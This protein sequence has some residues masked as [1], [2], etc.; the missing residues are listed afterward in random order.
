METSAWEVLDTISGVLVNVTILLGAAV[1]VI[2]F[3][4]YNILGHRYRSEIACAHEELADGRILFRGNYIVHNIGERQIRINKV[5]LKLHKA[6][7]RNGIVEPDDSVV[8]AR[9]VV[10]AGGPRKGLQQ[11]E[12]GERSIFTLRTII[13]DLDEVT[14]FACRIDW[15]YHRIPSPYLG[16]YVK[17]HGK[18][19]IREGV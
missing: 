16:L 2:K 8:A 4:L 6:A 15:D 7:L 14:F 5:H 13:D 11:I 10:G 19:D 17:A 12:A 3:R 1:A 18:A 9:T